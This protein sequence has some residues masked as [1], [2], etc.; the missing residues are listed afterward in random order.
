[1]LARVSAELTAQQLM[2]QQ[3]QQLMAQQQ[4]DETADQDETKNN[5]MYK[6]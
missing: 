2:V 1:M 4:Q 6:K 3:Q 5:I